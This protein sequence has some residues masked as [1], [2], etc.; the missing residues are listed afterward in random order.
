MILHNECPCS[1]VH[2]DALI[3]VGGGIIF[4]VPFPIHKFFIVVH[5]VV[6]VLVD[7][8]FGVTPDSVSVI[9]SGD[10]DKSD[11]DNPNNGGS[12]RKVKTRNKSCP[13]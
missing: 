12:P 7:L 3:V 4:S 9:I 2:I 5:I 11:D 8:H 13:F 1:Q 6:V 10:D